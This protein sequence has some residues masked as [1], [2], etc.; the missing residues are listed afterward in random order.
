MQLQKSI[1]QFLNSNTGPGI[2]LIGCVVVSLIIANSPI[3]PAFER[4]LATELGYHAEWIHLKYPVLL[5]VNDGLMALFFLLVG[6]EIKK[7]LVKG[8][9]SSPKSAALP[10]LA[11]IGGV[12]VPA[13]LY[14]F[15]NAG[16]D[17]AGG[18]AIP[19]AT[20]IA[21][22]LAIVMMLGKKVPLSLKIFLAALAI[23]DDL[24]AIM[25]IAIFYASDLNATYLLY[26]AGIFVMLLA[27]NRLGIRNLVFYV[28]PGVF[29]WYFIHHSGIHA[30]IAGVLTAFTIPV[31]TRKREKQAPLDRLEHALAQ[32]V[33]LMIMPL[34][35]L[36]NTNIA[37]ESSM[38]EGLLT[39]LGLGIILGLVVGKPLGVFLITWISV[40]TGLCSLPEKASWS[41][42]LG[43][44]ML[45]GI[46]FT[47]SIFIAVLSFTGQE[48]LMSTAK[49]SVLLASLISALSGVLCL[50]YWGRKAA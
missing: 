44:G 42:I 39:P 14:V 34:F 7:E 26:A 30:T 45:A 32:P 49:F 48:H 4:L 24:M 23:V 17:T 9:L 18:W 2:I 13:L 43:V 50:T 36:V 5:W 20:D 27:F 10:V 46:G 37:F 21:F 15:F 47:M 19:M 35:A 31:T 22:A 41:Q 1:K 40:R 3:G 25:V 29:I 38:I 11:A 28:I 16:T 6:L 8:H 12:A 33:N